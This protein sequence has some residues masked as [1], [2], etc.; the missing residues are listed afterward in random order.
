[1]CAAEAIVV[2][3]EPLAGAFVHSGM[4][5]L[6]GQK[7]SKSLGNLELVSRLR[8][9]GADPMAIRLALLAHHF[10]SDWEWH[11]SDLTDAEERLA[12][13]RG[14]RN[15]SSAVPAAGAISQIRAA[16]RDDLNAPAALAI[17]DAW[18]AAS[19]ATDGDDPQAIDDIFTLVDALLGVS[20]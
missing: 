6:D 1:M 3:A 10:R 16:M 17:V 5:G 12:L 20:V 8:Q 11:A 15:N 13:W 19:L 18:V 9:Q 7:M 14:M 2:T 4:V